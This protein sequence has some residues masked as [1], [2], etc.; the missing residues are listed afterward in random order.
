MFIFHFRS[1]PIVMVRVLVQWSF[2]GSRSEGDVKG[3]LV[4]IFLEMLWL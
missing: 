2:F 1:G 3:G 4:D